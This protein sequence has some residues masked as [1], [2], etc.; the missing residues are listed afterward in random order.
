MSTETPSYFSTRGTPSPRDPISFEEAVFTGLAPDGGLFIPTFIPKFSAEE[1]KELHELNNSSSLTFHHIAFKIMRKFIPNKEITDTELVSI[2]KDSYKN[3]REESVTPLKHLKSNV[4]ALELFHGPTF[5]F[6]D[7]ALQYLGNLFSFFLSK[8][9][10]TFLTV[11]GATSGDTGSSAIHGLK[12]F[13]NINIFILFPEGKVSPIQELQMTTVDDANVHCVAV[14]GTFDDAQRIVKSSFQNPEFKEKVHLSAV[15]SINFARILAQITYYFHAYFQAI[16]QRGE[17]DFELSF[18]VPTGNFGDILAGWYAK[19]MGLPV[20]DL[21]VATNGNDI[22][23]RFF[24]H[25]AYTQDGAVKATFAPS[26]DIAVSSNFERYLFHQKAILEN[27]EFDKV[28]IWIK[29]LM[30]RIKAENGVKFDGVE[31]KALWKKCCDDMRATRCGDK[32]ILGVVKDMYE[33]T[34]KNYVLDPHSACAVFGVKDEVDTFSE[35][36]VRVCLGCAHWGKFS[37][38]IEKAVGSEEMK[39]IK[40]KY[41][42]QLAALE[43]KEKRKKVM[44]AEENVVQTYILEKLVLN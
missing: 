19:E 9:P 40:Q 7:V 15:N 44:A 33:K 18:S 3:F 39:A 37:G 6:K 5:A 42:E 22:L 36:D 20:K 31:E 23:Y 12:N 13:S 30:D 35:R 24:D 34:G 8:R 16:K 4:Y 32:E 43:G 38:A 28:C 11:L 29:S 26:M 41:P 17:S 14:E 2:I 25:G 27:G 1:L 10:K 21:I